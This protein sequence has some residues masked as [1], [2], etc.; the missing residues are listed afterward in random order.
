MTPRKAGIDGAKQQR[1]GGNAPPAQAIG[2]L[3]VFD[4]PLT[5]AMTRALAARISQS[6]R[7]AERVHFATYPIRRV[8]PLASCGTVS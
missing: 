6:C 7:I 2:H 8:C 4:M 3:V 5:R 1:E